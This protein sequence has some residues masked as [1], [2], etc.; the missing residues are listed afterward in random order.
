MTVEFVHQE[1]P[2]RVVFGS[3]SV[4]RLSDETDRLGILRAMIV[5]AADRPRDAE[6]IA[7]LIGPRAAT[8]FA[9]AVMHTPSD[10]TERALSVVREK[11]IDGLV[12]FGG[13]SAVGLGKALAVRT[14]LPQICIPVTYAGSEMTPILGETENGRKT[15]RRSPEILPETVIYDVDLTLELSKRMSG[16]SGLNAVAHAVE[17]L[18]S[19]ECSPIVSLMAEEAIAAFARA[20]PAIMRDG[21]DQAARRDALFGAWLAGACLAR[22]GMGLHHKLCH[23]VG[24]MFDLPHAETHAVLLPHALAYNAPAVPEAV[25]RI[26]RA[27][28]A[29]HAVAG[30]SALAEAVGAPRSLAALGMP[31][32]GIDRAVEAALAVPYPNPR[33]PS[34]EGL[35]GLIERAWAGA[36]P[37][38]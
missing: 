25:G 8:A 4:A 10:V 17:A 35:R 24:G 33:P 11:T 9:G 12:V 5:T 1:L 37:Q 29:D 3:G 2:G 28:R 6:R 22:A 26:A 13:G 7:D 19:K 32:E 20:L 21:S 30:L 36:P 34:A 18:Y 23:V 27:L 14:G 15:T 16:A 31:R 38:P